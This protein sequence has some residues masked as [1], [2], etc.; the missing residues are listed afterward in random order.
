M[1]Q[2]QEAGFTQLA[3]KLPKGWSAFINS[4]VFSVEKLY[5][6]EFK[7]LKN[8]FFCYIITMKTVHRSAAFCDTVT[9]SL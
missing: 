9:Q 2:P 7:Q 5:E 3:E 4:I 1:G 6:K 8:C